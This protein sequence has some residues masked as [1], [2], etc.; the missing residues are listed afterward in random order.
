[1]AD[2]EF[3]L[4]RIERGNDIEYSRWP[5]TDVVRYTLPRSG[6]VERSNK[7]FTDTICEYPLL[8]YTDDDNARYGIALWV[9]HLGFAVLKGLACSITIFHLD[10]DSGTISVQRGLQTNPCGW[11]ERCSMRHLC[12]R[13]NTILWFYKDID[14]NN[15]YHER[16]VVAKLDDPDSVAVRYFHLDWDSVGNNHAYSQSVYSLYGIIFRL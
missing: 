7:V 13:G 11:V 14:F 9:A 6:R 16:L 5:L 10:Y 3:A 15:G 1:M 12:I 8:T 4:K 2:K